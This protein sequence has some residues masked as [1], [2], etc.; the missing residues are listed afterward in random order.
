MYKIRKILP[1]FKRQFERSKTK[2]FAFGSLQ[3]AI[4][5]SLI[6]DSTTLTLTTQTTRKR[7]VMKCNGCLFGLLQDFP[8][9]FLPYLQ[10]LSRRSSRR[11]QTTTLNTR[12]SSFTTLPLYINRV[13]MQVSLLLR[14]FQIFKQETRKSLK[15]HVFKS[16]N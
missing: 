16:L 8:L 10:Q 14:G 6:C 15:Q 2:S 13:A 11:F 7:P 4:A 3:K 1:D 5:F 9:N 12:P